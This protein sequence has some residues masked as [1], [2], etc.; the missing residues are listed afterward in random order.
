MTSKS[1]LPCLVKK[2]HGADSVAALLVGAGSGVLVGAESSGVVVASTCSSAFFCSNRFFSSCSRKLAARRAR[3]ASAF[4]VNVSTN[5]LI[6]RCRLWAS[7]KTVNSS[8]SQRGLCPVVSMDSNPCV[9]GRREGLS[10]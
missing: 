1:V 7:S 5:K 9:D 6:L 3:A 8:Q 4:E 10:G 2:F